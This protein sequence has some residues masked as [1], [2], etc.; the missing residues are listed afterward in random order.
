MFAMFAN[1]GLQKILQKT[2]IYAQT[3]LCVFMC[4]AIR[5]RKKLKM[6]FYF[7][8]SKNRFRIPYLYTE[9]HE[10][11]LYCQAQALYS[12]MKANA[13]SARHWQVQ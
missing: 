13:S 7:H 12:K 4:L 2:I 3:G 9:E 10:S 1:F 11:K 8:E 6:R 5:K